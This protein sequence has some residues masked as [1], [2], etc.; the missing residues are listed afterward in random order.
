M[1]A[2]IKKTLI[3]AKSRRT[4]YVEFLRRNGVSRP[5]NIPLPNATHWNSWFKMAFYVEEYLQFIRDFYAQEHEENTSPAIEKIVAILND[6]Q[7]YGRVW[8]NLAFIKNY[9]QQFVRDL[10]FFQTENV[11][12]FPYIEGHIE[13]LESAI[14]TGKSLTTLVQPVLEVFSK[15][16]TE[17]DLFFSLFRS[18]YQAAYNKF[19]EHISNHPTRPLFQETRIFDPRFILLSTISHNIASYSYIREF[20]NPSVDLVQEWAVYCNFNLAMVEFHTLDEFWNKVSYQLPLLS[21]IAFDYIWLPISS[22]SVER[23]FSA[24]NKI[25]SDDRQNLSKESLRALTTMYYNQ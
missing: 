9:G 3:Y 11:P 21:E 12:V 20:A 18:A 25:L 15:L 14:N 6:Q 5:N 13:Q 24:Y 2:E 17:P 7:E 19:S 1:L 8:I 4:R 22:C 23:S 16:N 10:D